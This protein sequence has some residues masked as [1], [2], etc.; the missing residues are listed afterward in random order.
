[1]KKRADAIGFAL[2][3]IWWGFK[4][5]PNYKIHTSLSILTVV[6]GIFLHVSYTE[7]LILITMMCLGFVIETINTAIEQLGDAIDTAYNEHIKQA[8]DSAAGAM[9]LFAFGA[10]IVAG[11]IFIPKVI[12]LF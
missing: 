8:K 7:W 2:S 4:T 5:Q 1:M 11:W 10:V 3:G 6:A 12:E 9:L